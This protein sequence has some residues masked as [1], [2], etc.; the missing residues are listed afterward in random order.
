VRLVLFDWLSS[1]LHRPRSADDP[2]YLHLTIQ[3][4]AAVENGVRLV[5]VKLLRADVD[6]QTTLNFLLEGC[7]LWHLRHPH[8]VELI[9]PDS[10]VLC[11]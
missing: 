1:A 3:S 5:A 4:R 2:F 7:L 11:L 10:I 8:V 9:G 6:A